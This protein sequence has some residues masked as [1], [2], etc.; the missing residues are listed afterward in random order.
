MS[1][2]AVVWLV[3]GLVTTVA[4]IA[5]LIGLIRHLLVLGR[6]LRGFQEAVTPLAEEISAEADRA[7]GRTSRL[8]AQRPFGREL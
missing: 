8:S 6:S 2:P 7:A 3:V 1:T 5:V 4:M